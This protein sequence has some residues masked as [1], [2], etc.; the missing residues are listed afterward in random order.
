[1]RLHGI[2]AGLA[3]LGALAVSTFTGQQKAVAAGIC[4]LVVAPVCALNRDGT[5]SNYTNTCLPGCRCFRN[6]GPGM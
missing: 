4:P 6:C 2:A 3:L 1:M 5:R